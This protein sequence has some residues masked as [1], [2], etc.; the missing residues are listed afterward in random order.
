MDDK[1]VMIMQDGKVFYTSE[2][3]TGAPDEFKS[4]T[5]RMIYDRLARAGIEYTRI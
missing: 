1:S 5:Q 3:M 2:V 4:E